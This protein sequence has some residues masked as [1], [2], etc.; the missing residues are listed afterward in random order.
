MIFIMKKTL[1][2]VMLLLA[3]ILVFHTGIFAQTAKPL[4]T[5]DLKTA[6]SWQKVTPLGQ[7]IISTP[8]GLTGIHTET[9]A[10]LWTIASLKNSPEN[11]YVPIENS[12]YVSLSSAGGGDRN[13][14]D[15]QEG[16]VLFNSTAAGLDK[17]TDQFFL[18][19]NNKILVIGTSNGGKSTEVV[20]ADMATGQKLWSKTG[21]YSFTTAAYDLGSNE[22]LVTSAFFASK[23]NSNT[24][25]EIWKTPIDPRTAGFGALLGNL[26]GMA[27]GKITKEEIMAQLIVPPSKQDMFIIAAQKKHESTKTDSK[28]NKSVSISYT[29]VYMAFNIA[30]GKHKWGSVAEMRYPLGVSYA[31]NEG[32]IVTSSAGGNVNMLNYED[33]SPML[34]KKGGGINVK[35]P[36]VGF[37]PLADGKILI[38]S[39]NGGSSTIA[40]LD[41]KGGVLTFDKA[42]KIKGEVVYTEILPGGVL[43][44]TSKEVNMLNLATGD[45]YFENAIEGGSGLIASNEQK[46]YIFNAKDGLV[47]QMDVNAT[48]VKPVNT[49]PVKFQ[50]KEIPYAIEITDKG[51][52]LTSDQNLALVDNSG[53]IVFNK[54]FPAP[55]NSGF[56]KALLIANAVRAAY[57]TAAF[58]TYSA[59]FGAASQSIQVKDAQSKA[60]KDVT[61][62]VSRGL[63]E[64]AV[65]G[66]KYTASYIKMVGERYKAT[67]QARDYM[68]VMT[69]ESKNDIRLVQV[70]KKDGSVM[71][72]IQIGKDKDPVYDVD[73]VDGK[74]YYMKG[75]TQM[76]CYKF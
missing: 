15:T 62:A 47:Y 24:G 6:V 23:L 66:G 35:G 76:E 59:A 20:M 14:V 64:A 54:Y 37:V 43:V 9:G 5:T 41:P 39:D 74:L 56:R 50:G 70:S 30:D 73:L 51:V 25:D 46:V 32:L 63:G 21:P 18:Y 3:A 8:K 58:A 65:T 1:Q 34:G 12:P 60:T 38:I 33:G 10:E 71:N 36:A 27:A 22:V 28:G 40:A 49:V 19:R 4:W 72:T 67:T 29:S 53:A 31:A 16:K 57:Y 7:L 13:I 75:S 68:L 11:S 69:A 52:L 61:A 26:E 55:G 42:A 45:W 48:S 17:I 2:L 44:G